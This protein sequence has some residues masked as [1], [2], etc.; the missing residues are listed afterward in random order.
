MHILERIITI[1]APHECLACGLEGSL[2]CLGCRQSEFPQLPSRCYKCHA[3]TKVAHVCV[4]CRRKNTLSHVWVRT[5]YDGMAK[6]LI[7]ALKFER[8]KDAAN[9]AAQLM[10]ES[11]PFLSPGT[12]IVPVPTATSRIRQRGYD[13]AWL[14]ARH[15]AIL[16]GMTPLK[17][18]V[19]LGQNRQVGATRSQRQSQMTDAF[20]VVRPQEVTGRRIILVD[21]VVTTGASLEAAARTLKLAGAS[22]VDA[23]VFAQ[24]QE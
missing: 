14:I 21:D 6:R 7:H 16:R 11:L 13:H 17:V 5:D 8:A 23:I 22:R 15:I 3:L 24:K 2:L 9:H 4:R 1:I 12:L 18:L 10:E 19:R 20:R